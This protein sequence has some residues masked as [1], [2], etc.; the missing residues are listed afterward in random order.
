MPSGPQLKERFGVAK[1][2]TEHAI[3]ILRDE[4]LVVSRKGS[5]VYVRGR[6]ERPVGLGPHIERSFEA[7]KVT[8]DF[9]GFSGE[10]LHHAIAEPIDRIRDG[11]LRPESLSVRNP[12]P[13]PTVASS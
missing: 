3:R 1:A 6:T 11:L 9:A 13:I 12:T 2:T 8:I 5:G 10:T 4:G 7:F